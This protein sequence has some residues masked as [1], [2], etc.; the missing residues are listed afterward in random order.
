MRRGNNRNA[1]RL[2]CKDGRREGHPLIEFGARLKELVRDGALNGF[3]QFGAVHHLTDEIAVAFFG[4][5]ASGGGMRLAQVAHFSESRHLI[6]NGRRR[7]IDVVMLR[8][9]LR[10]NGLGSIDV[11]TDD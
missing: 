3:G 9:P 1:L 5:H 11:I 8:Q 4:G 6:T 7:Q 2:A 10:A